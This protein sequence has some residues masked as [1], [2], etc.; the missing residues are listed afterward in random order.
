MQVTHDCPPPPDP[1]PVLARGD[2]HFTVGPGGEIR[3][4]WEADPD[5]PGMTCPGCRTSWIFT[6]AGW[7][8]LNE[9]TE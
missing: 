2:Q 9:E 4:T 3:M 1:P 6:A 7:L 5:N 8:P